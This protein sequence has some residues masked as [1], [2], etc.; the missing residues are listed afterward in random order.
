MQTREQIF[1]QGVYELVVRRNSRDEE[2][3]KK[4][5]ALAHKLPV[6]IRTAGLA[7]AL[8][9][10]AT[11]ENDQRALFVDLATVL[12]YQDEETLLADSRQFDLP[13]YMRLTHEALHALLWFKR[14]AQSVL[15]VAAVRK[16]PRTKN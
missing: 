7:Q 11:R 12:G 10:A 3:K 8:A 4:Y 9:F 2:A 5:V 14:Y 6:L 16:E 1:A 13:A 15:E